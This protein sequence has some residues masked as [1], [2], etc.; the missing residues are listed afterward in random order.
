MT[1]LGSKYSTNWW[2]K[3]EDVVP[4]N[5]ADCMVVKLILE[6]REQ[7][8]VPVTREMIWLKSLSLIK[9]AFPNPKFLKDGSDG[10]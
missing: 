2:S 10:F 1:F 9:P 8:H 6:K 4:L 7:S 3:L 5:R